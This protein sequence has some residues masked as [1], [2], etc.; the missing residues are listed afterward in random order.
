MIK[1]TGRADLYLEN[2]EKN[3]FF[4]H[5]EVIFATSNREEDTLGKFL[6]RCGKITRTQYEESQLHL[7]PGQKHGKTLV[8]LGLI[9]PKDLWWGVKHQILEIIYDLFTWKS[10]KFLFFETPVEAFQQR[11]FINTSTLNII[12]EGVRRLDEWQRIQEKIPSRTMVFKKMPIGEAHVQSLDLSDSEQRLLGLVDGVRTVERLMEELGLPEFETQRALLT[13]IVA[14]LV[15]PSSPQ[16]KT[17]TELDDRPHLKRIAE[18]YNVLFERIFQDLKASMG[19]LEAQH[20]MNNILK[21]N[22][23]SMELFEEISFN[24]KGTFDE[25]TLIANV[26]ELPVEERRQVLDDTLNTLLSFFLFE[27][28]QHLVT[29]AKNRLYAD[30]SRAQQDWGEDTLPY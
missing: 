9:S 22:P 8:K 21:E 16:E 19:A 24:P 15:V 26:S 23:V 1:K 3:I 30:I 29:D 27:V 11:I 12:L 7:K 4:K 17:G 20:S 14:Q 6:V 28:A 13:L 10:G 5:G 18:R 2:V 25:N